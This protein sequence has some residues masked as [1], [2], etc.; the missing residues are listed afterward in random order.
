MLLNLYSMLWCHD[1]VI[2]W[3]HFPRFWPVMRGIHRS[4]VNSSQ[5]GQ[6]R[7][8]LIFS[9]I[10]AW[11]KG[12][13]NNRDAGDLRR[14]RAHYDVTTMVCYSFLFRHGPRHVC[15]CFT[16]LDQPGVQSLPLPVT[17]S[18]T[19][20]ANCEY[21]TLFIIDNGCTIKDAWLMK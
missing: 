13:V 4:P 15:K 21:F 1:D 17:T 16:R 14:H 3:K 11:T 2:K 7:G 20:I 5:K 12:W 19:T 9:L 18:L 8:A 6:R 10:C